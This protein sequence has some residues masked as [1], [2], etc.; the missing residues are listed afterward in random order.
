MKEL[1]EQV[2]KLSIEV[3]YLRNQNNQFQSFQR[4]NQGGNQ[5]NNYQNHC[6]SYQGGYQRNHQEG[7]YQRNYQDKYYQRNNQGGSYQRNYQN[8][9]HQC[10]NQSQDQGYN[11]QSNQKRTWSTSLNNGNVVSPLDN[12]TSTDSRPVDR[13]FLAESAMSKYCRFHETDKHLELGCVEF[14]RASNLFQ[15]IVDE[16]IN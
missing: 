8:N 14:N 13:I 7:G 6:G 4:N 15:N 16:S 11:N 5:G 9:N 1:I 10:N 2:K 12:Q 3:T